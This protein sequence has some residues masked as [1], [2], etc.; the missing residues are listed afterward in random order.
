M[1]GTA[2]QPADPCGQAVR[3]R[4]AVADWPVTNAPP[5]TTRA[6]TRIVRSPRRR[7]ATMVSYSTA[8]ASWGSTRSHP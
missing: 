3:T 6:T 2:A 1:F 7:Y 8:A 4:T 5:V